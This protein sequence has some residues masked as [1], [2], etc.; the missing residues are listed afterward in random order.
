[1]AL[2]K[3]Y[4]ANGY[5]AN[6]IKELNE[7]FVKLQTTKTNKPTLVEVMIP[8]KDLAGQMKNLTPQVMNCNK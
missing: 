4:G 3:A 5:Q 7:V 8:E 2:A 6:N 1:M